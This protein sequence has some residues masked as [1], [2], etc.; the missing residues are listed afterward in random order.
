MIRAMPKASLRSVLLICILSAAFAS[1]AS[2][3]MIGSPSYSIRSIATLMSLPSRDRCG[4]SVDPPLSDTTDQFSRLVLGV[5]AERPRARARPAAFLP[6]CEPTP[7]GLDGSITPD[8]RL[9]SR[10]GPRS[11]SWRSHDGSSVL[12]RHLNGYLARR[13]SRASCTRL[14]APRPDA[15]LPLH[16]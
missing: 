2:I 12:T 16:Y 14:F 5:S 15:R 9:G 3:Q 4:G 7:L 11:L 13:M 1:L 6:N 10:P 8:Q